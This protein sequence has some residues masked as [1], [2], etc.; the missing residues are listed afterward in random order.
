MA[1]APS[2]TGSGTVS[3]ADSVTVLGDGAGPASD[4]AGGAPEA[5]GA[6]ETA[7]PQARTPAAPVA[8]VPAVPVVPPPAAP[9]SAEIR[10][11]DAATAGRMTSSWREGCPVPLS[12]LRLVL[13]SFVGYDG[14]PHI[15]ELV[16]HADVANDVVA[17]FRTL[18]AAR[19]SIERMEL[20]DVY[21][22]SDDASMAA[23]NTSAF[24]CRFATGSDRWSQHAYGRAIDVNPL[25]NPYVSGSYVAPP[26]GAPYVDRTVDAPGMVRAG[27]VV[28]RAFASIGW[29]WGGDYSSVKD[30]QHFSATGR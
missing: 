24:N 2:T 9:Y 18:F 15:G 10:T 22:G 21:G 1:A 6:T 19:F 29:G 20:V 23:N 12:D 5:P 3:A 30:Y 14:D 25:V 28:V 16:V 13:V 4:A 26:G 11:I 8:E 7:A 17:V 27:D